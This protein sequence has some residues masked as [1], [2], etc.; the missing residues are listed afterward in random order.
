MANDPI[1]KVLAE[2][3]IADV[4]DVDC[5]VRLEAGDRYYLFGE[6]GAQYDSGPGL[7]SSTE[8]DAVRARV[9]AC[10]PEAL[11]L[12]LEAEWATESAASEFWD[13]CPWCR[14]KRKDGHDDEDPG[15]RCPWL[16]LMR[17]AGLR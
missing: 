15:P 4:A 7:P 6:P 3:W 11:Q 9:A 8:D 16:D 14:A 1:S 13:H 2:A 10:A 5:G 17:K 12:L